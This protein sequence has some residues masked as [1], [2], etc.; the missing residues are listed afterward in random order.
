MRP[1]LVGLR[2]HPVPS[3]T[4]RDGVNE[5]GELFRLGI[6]HLVERR[7]DVVQ[8][9]DMLELGQIG[10][11]R[12]AQQPSRVPEDGVLDHDSGGLARAGTGVEQVYDYAALPQELEQ[13]RPKGR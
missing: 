8:H 9:A 2:I 6:G 1:Q 4:A 3:S 12:G 10:V 13:R 7:A 5:V 11:V